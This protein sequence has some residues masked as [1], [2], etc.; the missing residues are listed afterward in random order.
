MPTPPL[1]V[2]LTV[3]TPKLRGAASFALQYTL[4]YT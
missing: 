4:D 3:V 2:V 1:I